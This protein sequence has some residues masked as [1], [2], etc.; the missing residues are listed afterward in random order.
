M[1]KRKYSANWYHARDR[2][3]EK[4]LLERFH[5]RDLREAWPDAKIVFTEDD[6]PVIYCGFV[7]G[8]H[9]YFSRELDLYVFT[10]REAAPSPTAPY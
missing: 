6:W 2:A 5:L 10:I 9:Y 3:R 4:R 1:T 7:D 8:Q